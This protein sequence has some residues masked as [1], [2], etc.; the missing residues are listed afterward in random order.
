VRIAAAEALSAAG[1]PGEALPVLAAALRSPQETVRLHA[2]NVIDL[3]GP[4]ARAILGDLE[5]ALAAEP[6]ESYPR[7]VLPRTIERLRAAP[8]GRSAGRGR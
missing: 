3:L 2:A 6:E 7:R 4:D 1:R 8:S 5:T